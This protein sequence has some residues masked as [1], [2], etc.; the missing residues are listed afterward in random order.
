MPV[1]SQLELDRLTNQLAQTMHSQGRSVETVF[2][3][4]ITKGGTRAIAEFLDEIR[5]K[6]RRKTWRRSVGKQITVDEVVHKM[7]VYSYA[8]WKPPNHELM[9]FLLDMEEA[10]VNITLDIKQK[11]L[12]QALQRKDPEGLEI[13]A[14]AGADISKCD[15]PLFRAAW[16]VPSVRQLLTAGADVNKQAY[17]G[18]TPL[19]EASA[20]GSEDSVKLL[21][22]AVANVNQPDEYCQTPLIEATRS[23]NAKCVQLLLQAEADVHHGKLET[24][25][26]I[27]VKAKDLFLVRI[28]LKAGACLNPSLPCTAE[29]LVRA[30]DC[31]DLQCAL[32][33]LDAG[34]N[35]NRCPYRPS[36]LMRAILYN[37]NPNVVKLL[38]QRGALI[39]AGVLLDDNYFFWNCGDQ[40]LLLAGLS[41]A[42]GCKDVMVKHGDQEPIKFLHT[43]RIWI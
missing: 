33:L 26:D 27:A 3:T 11:T 28:L 38:L 21:V 7:F 31:T 23:G 20:H 24:A 17:H 5:A 10:D 16:H 25:L 43:G 18:R 22:E 2:H 19:M 6:V 36:P 1:F 32:L 35:V 29:T 42:A 8:S 34:A 40:I 37:K 9:K 15:H 4:I 14:S 41:F 13:L 39:P 12:I 30:M